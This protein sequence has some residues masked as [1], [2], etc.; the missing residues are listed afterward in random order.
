MARQ[1][2]K[3]WLE[4]Y[5]DYID[6][7]ENPTD[8]NLW[9]GISAISAS[10]KRRVYI[11]RN[12][13]QYFPNQYIVLVG[14]PGIGKG[15]SIH[16]VTDIVNDAGTVNYLSDKMTAERVI[17]KLADGFTKVSPSVTING[18][19]STVSIAQ[20]HTA[21]IL[22]K[23]LPVFL[24]SSEWLHALLC[25]LWDEHTFE[26][27]TK[28]KGSY[29]ITELCVS[30]LAGCVPEFIRMLSRDNMAPIT[31][32]FTARTIFVYASE[33][34][35]LLSG[36]WG[37]P[38]PNIT[39]LKSELIN[40][41]IHISSLQGEMVFDNQALT[42]WDSKYKEH[43]AAGDFDSDVSANFKSRL[44]SHIIKAAITISVSESDSLIVTVSQLQR[45]ISLI[46]RIRDKVDIVFRSVGESPLAVSQN[47]VL[48]FIQQTGVASREEIL[49]KNYRHMTDEQLTAI[50]LVLTRA[51]MIREFT[52]DHKSK[53][54]SL[55]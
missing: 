1:L 8:F 43:N 10:L 27:E 45:A 21:T 47:R 2:K 44:S 18:G 33:K 7:T 54:E 14:P 53:Y 49:R 29:K 39:Q 38:I 16:P 31:G 28:N 42:L 11:W 6:G 30:M 20:D 17:Q 52:Q 25:Q 9:S 15:A 24:S 41:L 55:V 37:R 26:Y 46:E 12:F 32:G 35:K 19:V 23:E 4:A 34:S 48:D 40:D 50:I 22:A 5:L 36:G 13:V 3:P 51:G